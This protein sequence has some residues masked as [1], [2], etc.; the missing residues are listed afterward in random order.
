MIHC[1]YFPILHVYHR[2]LHPRSIPLDYYGGHH[3][4]TRERS[5]ARGANTMCYTAQTAESLTRDHGMASH[6]FTSD[7]IAKRHIIGASNDIPVGGSVEIHT[8]NDFRSF[9]QVHLSSTPTSSKDGPHRQSYL[10]GHSTISIRGA[11]H[12]STIWRNVS[13]PLT[14]NPPNFLPPAI[15]I[16][17]PG[18][19]LRPPWVPYS[20]S[21]FFVFF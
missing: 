8:D 7:C 5:G 17:P 1:V 13:G 6:I 4:Q 12:A 14:N 16:F 19:R 18:A 10:R 15:T 9:V 21:I 2:S 3:R 11:K 20:I